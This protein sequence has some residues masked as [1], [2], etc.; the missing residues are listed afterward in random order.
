M[1]V[2][3]RTGMAAGALLYIVV[4]GPALPLVY[5]KQAGTMYNKCMYQP[6][7]VQT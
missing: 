1:L 2:M 5:L 7:I 4:V 3:R 6:R